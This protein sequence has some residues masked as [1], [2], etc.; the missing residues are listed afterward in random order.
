MPA[1]EMAASIISLRVFLV[2]DREVRAV[3][4]RLG[5][6]AEEPVGRRVERAAPDPPRIDGDELLDAREHLAG[7]LVGE[8]QQQDVR[9]I[10]AV[11]DQARNAVGEGAGFAAAGAGDDEDRAVARH[12]HLELLGFSSSS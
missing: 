11:L 1:E 2:E 7:G 4:D 5:V 8:G 10:D 12:H 9:R 6:P 3:A